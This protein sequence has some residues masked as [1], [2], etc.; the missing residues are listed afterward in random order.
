[1]KYLILIISLILF[2]SCSNKQKEEEILFNEALILFKQKTN[3]DSLPKEAITK[4]NIILS[5]FPESKLAISIESEGKKLFINNHGLLTYYE[6]LE[7]DKNLIKNEKAQILFDEACN[8][9]SISTNKDSI[10]AQAVLKIKMIII[11]YPKTRLAKSLKL[12]V[13]RIPLYNSDPLTFAELIELDD[14]LISTK[15]ANKLE[16]TSTLMNLAAQSKA[17]Y[18]TPKTHGGGGKSFKGLMNGWMSNSQL[19]SDNSFSYIKTKYSTVEIEDNYVILQ[20]KSKFWQMQ[21]KVTSDDIKF[22]SIKR[23]R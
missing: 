5:N 4:L 19:S 1:M 7:L 20:G 11:D 14:K 13:Q 15:K 2:I 22:L 23:N 10:S 17:Y 12:N 9:L 8:L 18:K 21:L 16:I 3:I 6:I